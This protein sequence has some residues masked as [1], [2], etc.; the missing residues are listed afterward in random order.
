MEKNLDFEK[1]IKEMRELIEILI[2]LKSVKEQIAESFDPWYSRE[3]YPDNTV[4]G[5]S[6]CRENWATGERE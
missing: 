1:E 2:A 6:T 4:S 3:Q 5:E